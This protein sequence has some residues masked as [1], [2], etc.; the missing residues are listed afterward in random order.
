MSA[1]GQRVATAALLIP[2]VTVAILYLPTPAFALVAGAFAAAGAWEWAAFAGWGGARSR[3]LY[4]AAFAAASAAVYPLLGQPAGVGSLL[5]AALLWWVLATV[6]VVRFQA[7]GGSVL[8]SPLARG[9]AGWLV[10]LPA[11]AALVVLHRHQPLGPWLVVFLMVTIWC[12]DSAAYFVGRRWG[13]RRLASRVSPGK[14]W[15]GAAGGVA[16]VL[17]LGLA[18]AGV[19][20][21]SDYLPAFLG[22]VMATA[23]ASILGDL[24]ESLYKRQAGLKDSGSLLPGHGGVLD[25][26]D[27]LTSA[28]PL[29]V[30]GLYGMG[31]LP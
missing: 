31:R 6:L 15:E 21:F 12:A 25:R 8:G 3:G 5:A 13:R 20:G 23:L 4:A 11:W 30:L 2:L 1:L 19:L 27:S 29:F 16:A 14:S 18:V 24:L 26:I 17:L 28:A 22:L 9:A 7:V 10:L